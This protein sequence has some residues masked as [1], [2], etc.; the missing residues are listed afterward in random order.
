MRPDAPTSPG[1]SQ[2][3]QI[4]RVRQVTP[5]L[6]VAE[7]DIGPVRVGS[8]WIGGISAGDP[9]VNWPRSGKGFPVITIANDRLRES[10]EARLIERVKG[11]PA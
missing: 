11:W 5:D 9:F 10:I 2:P 8:V 3:F 4:A 1:H 7:L 6:A